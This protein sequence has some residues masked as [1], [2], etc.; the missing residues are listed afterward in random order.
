MDVLTDS[1]AL[2]SIASNTSADTSAL[3]AFMLL[4]E[5]G[6]WYDTPDVE[7]VL[8]ELDGVAVT[9]TVLV[10]VAAFGASPAEAVEDIEMEDKPPAVRIKL[11]CLAETFGDGAT[12]A[13]VA[14]GPVA[15]RTRS[16]GST[17]SVGVGSEPSVAVGPRA[18]VAVGS[19]PSVASVV[20]IG[21]GAVVETAPARPPV[22]LAIGAAAV[23][24]EP[25][26]ASAS[27]AKRPPAPIKRAHSFE[28]G[29]S[30][31]AGLALSLSIQRTL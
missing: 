1:V 17:E 26:G 5:Y 18:S 7:G 19:E 23:P 25:S 16:G 13:T 22:P 3:I 6:I 27:R 21:Y 8:P 14:A 2:T 30:R 28:S 15:R 29:K 12:A 31:G 24:G 4:E 20:V 9:Y 11:A 10:E